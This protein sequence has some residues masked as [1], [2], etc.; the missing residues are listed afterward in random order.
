M[1]FEKKYL[2]IWQAKETFIQKSIKLVFRLV[3]VLV[4]AQSFM[5]DSVLLSCW[6]RRSLRLVDLRGL[7]PGSRLSS[8][9]RSRAEVFAVSQARCASFGAEV[10]VLMAM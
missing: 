9:L 3:F 6:S 4:L 1:K 7:A 5:F 8:L 10:C 2:N